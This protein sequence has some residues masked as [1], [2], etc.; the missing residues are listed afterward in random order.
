MK[1]KINYKTMQSLTLKNI[2]DLD[3]CVLGALELFSSIKIPKIEISYKKPLVVGSGNAEATGRIIFEDKDAVFASES[4]FE[5]K[6]KNIKSIDGVVLISA[7]GGKHAPII[8][9]TSREFRKNVTL[10]TNNQNALAKEYSDRVFV[11]PKQK[12]PYT[13]NTSTYM[14]M[15]LGK[16]HESP[17]KI[18]DF[19]KLRIDKIKLPNL[20]RYDKYYLIVPPKFSGIIRMLNVKFIELFGRRVARDVETSEYVKHATTVVP[21]NELFISFGEENKN[22]GDKKNRLHIPLPKNADYGTIMAISY[23]LI[24]KIQKSHTPYFKK[25]ISNYTKSVSKIFGQ[26][27]KPIVE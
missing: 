13:Y 11:F 26:E 16:T 18:Y 22:W 10:I 8:A 24:G 6:L 14:G 4:N 9:K 2:P 15:I 3:V 20:G 12:E 5:E 25:N 27:I 23:Y 19:I 17:D 1:E 7:S 21:S